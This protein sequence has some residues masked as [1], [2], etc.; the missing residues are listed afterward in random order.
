MKY[1]ITSLLALF[2]V[3]V[4]SLPTNRVLAA[5]METNTAICDETQIRK[6]NMTNYID[7]IEKSGVKAEF[8]Y[9][10]NGEISKKIIGNNVTKYICQNDVIVAESN[11]YKELKYTYNEFCGDLKGTQISYKG[12][13]YDLE[14]DWTGNV[15]AIYNGEECVCTYEY[16]GCSPKEPKCIRNEE[17]NM[18]DEELF[19]GD[20]NPFLYQGWFY[21][22][23]IDCYYMGQGIFFDPEKEEFIQ[24]NFESYDVGINYLSD[25]AS[26]YSMSYS[27]I[28]QVINLYNT[29]MNSSLYG[30]SSYENVSQSQWN[31]GARWYTGIEKMELIAR[32]IWGESSYLDK[33]DDRT[34]IAAVIMNRRVDS[35]QSGYNVITASGQFSTINPEIYSGET[36]DDIT[37]KTLEARKSKSKTNAAW[38]QATMLA[39]VI[40]YSN[41]RNDLNYFYT[42]PTGITTQKSFRGLD[43]ATLSK[44]VSG[45]MVYV[46]VAGAER[47]NVAIAGYGVINTN[48]AY[49]YL[50]SLKDQKLHY[51]VFFD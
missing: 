12:N 33:T 39:C 15:V 8:F 32:C 46:S 1:T 41:D 3:V 7:C 42:L 24:N 51:T 45:S 21:D 19:I 25:I 16:D 38:Q 36:Y 34:G 28:N 47:S 26:T 23:D 20:I 22:H 14:Y 44:R 9:K 29:A 49:D 43:Y 2:L 50:V 4:L 48:N 13:T 17:N 11:R 40:M 27:Q 10:K 18:D 6:Q 31:S 5:N 30:A 35:G 37:R